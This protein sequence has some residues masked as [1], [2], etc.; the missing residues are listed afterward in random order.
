MHDS[1]IQ[2]LNELVQAWSSSA[3]YAERIIS[4]KNG[5]GTS[6]VSLEPAIDVLDDTSLDQLSGET[7]LDWFFKHSSDAILDLSGEIVEEL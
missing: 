7:Q 2:A 5:V 1:A 6:G 4:L 3:A